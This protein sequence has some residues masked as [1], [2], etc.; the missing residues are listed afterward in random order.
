MW[1]YTEGITRKTEN[2]YELIYSP[3]WE[4]RIYFTSLQDF[5][6]WNTLQNLRVPALFLRGDE[7]DTF[8]QD[9]AEAGKTKTTQ[10]QGRSGGKIHPYL[11]TGTTQG[12][13]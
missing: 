11:S 12:N 4:S 8:L 6:I 5:D 2:G 10:S 3:E 13:I 1:I 7:T 9:A